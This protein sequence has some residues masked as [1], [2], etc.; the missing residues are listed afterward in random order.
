MKI[1]NFVFLYCEDWDT[2][3]RTSK[4][5]FID[6]L[7]KEGHKI[8]YIEVPLNPLSVLLKPKTIFK[9]T[10]INALRGLRAVKK[11]IWAIKTIVPFPFHPILG[12]FTDNLLI[13]YLNQKFILI[14]LL[15]IL[16]KLKFNFPE[17]VIY[18]PMSVPILNELNFSKIY[19]HI[20]DDWQ[21]FKG[22]PKSMKR[23][24]LRLLELADVTIVT[25][26]TLYDRYFNNTSN[27]QLLGHGTDIALFS[28]IITKKIPTLKILKNSS[29][30]KVGYYGSL[31][32]LD[33]N[34]IN[35]VSTKMPMLEFYFV[36][37]ITENFNNKNNFSNVFFLNS[38]DRDKLPSFLQG[39]D[40]FWMPF[41]INELTKSM[42]P[43]KI[44]EVLSAGL[45]IVSVDLDEC[46]Y[47]TD[48]FI[49]FGKSKEEFIPLINN[50][51]NGNSYQKKIERLNFS[52][53][54]TWTK[55]YN[56]FK[57]LINI[58]AERNFDGNSR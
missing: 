35:Y 2:P 31:E 40:I 56:I 26:K 5:H 29:K 47:I 39:I 53:S 14:V 17:A 33:F 58:N 28:K 24:T 12:I 51:I 36:G 48:K 13:N 32:K 3:L 44:Y 37:P 4:H 15:K 38:L 54:F 25:S 52:K 18:Y 55:R 42:S 34:L 27:I 46:R 11:N 50:A 10:N 30:K 16:K 41:E 6:R 57:K 21:G 20:V 23:L 19:F 8:L 43:I 7:A 45:P 49:T 22:I 9:E 1:R